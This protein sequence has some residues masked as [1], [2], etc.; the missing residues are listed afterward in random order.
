V[1]GRWKLT[2]TETSSKKP[3]PDDPD[4]E[5]LVLHFHPEVDRDALV[6]LVETGRLFVAGPDAGPVPLVLDLDRD[7][8]AEVVAQVSPH[9]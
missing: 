2:A 9:P 5:V 8:V 3:T 1:S 6:Q 4:S 7:L